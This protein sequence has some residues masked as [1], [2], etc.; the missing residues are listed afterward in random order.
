MGYAESN[1][2]K[3]PDLVG[4][5]I[6]G[7]RY[8]ALQFM[9]LEWDHIWTKVWLLVGRTS[10]IPQSGDFLVEEIGPE[11]FLILRQND[12]SVRTFYNVCQRRVLA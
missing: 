7:E 5:P 8:T 3:K 12:G 10:E 2:W 6:T 9:R 4:T 11:S 1:P